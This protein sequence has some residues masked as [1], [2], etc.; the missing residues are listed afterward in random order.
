[1]SHHSPSTDLHDR[2]LTAATQPFLRRPRYTTDELVFH[3]EDNLVSGQYPGL[4]ELEVKP[5]DIET[6]AI[7]MIRHYRMPK[8]M[9]EL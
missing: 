2:A 3:Q 1:M 5:A 8:F 7:K 9:N 6:V 4:A